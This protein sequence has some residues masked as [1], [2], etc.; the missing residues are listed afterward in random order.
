LTTT[1]FAIALTAA[2]VASASILIGAPAASADTAADIHEV[3][4]RVN[5]VN[6]AIV[7]GWTISDL[8]VSTDSIPYA[9]KGTLWEAT[10]TD[11]AL[12]GG[13]TPIVSNFNA[14]AQS[15]HTYRALFQVPT[16][17]G[18]NPSSIAE[19]EKTS[20]KVYFD[21]TG[22]APDRVVY[23]AGGDDLLVW[24]QPQAPAPRAGGR[25]VPA[26]AGT[27]AAPAPG[28]TEVVPA[29]ASTAT[30]PSGWTGT[31]LP[32][33]R[34]GIPVPTTSAVPSPPAMAATPTS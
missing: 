11:E 1:T 25:F 16:Q 21:V 18:I 5:L 4:D 27:G 9:A 34:T 15:D 24:T 29:I 14:R 17:Q 26:Q 10:A 28:G 8:K 6:G 2:V 31:P 23:N 13:V 20:G 22:D 19:G 7:Q 12:A 30:P 3:G 33:G 32:S